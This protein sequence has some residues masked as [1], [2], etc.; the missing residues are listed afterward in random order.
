MAMDPKQRQQLMLLLIVVAVGAAGLFWYM[1]WK[2]KGVEVAGL[3]TEI[4]SLNTV[5]DAAKR[6][7]RAGTIED[8]RRRTADYE[9][10]LGLMRQLV[11]AQNEIPTLLDDIASRASLRGVE[12]ANFALQGTEPGPVFDTQRYQITVFG[13]YDEVGEFLADVASLQ[14]IMVPYNVSMTPAQSAAQ[15]A[16]ADTSGALIEAKFLLR[17]FVK[18]QSG[19]TSEGT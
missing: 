3:H 18:S 8:L 14:R 10:A 13:H 6:D 19:G 2:P 17:T 16:Y 4:D 1:W 12:M 7:L 9:A 5:I 15:Q 11:P